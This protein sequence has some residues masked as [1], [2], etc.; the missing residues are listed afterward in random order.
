MILAKIRE[1]TIGFHDDFTS[2]ANNIFNGTITKDQYKFV[3]KTFYG[4]YYPLEQK[5]EA[6]EE[7][8]KI[9]FNIEGRRKALLAVKD[10]KVLGVSDQEINEIETCNDL[11]EVNNL[12]QALGCMYVLEGAT[13]GGQ[14]TANKL[15]EIFDFT[16]ENGASFFSSYGENVRPMWKSFGD[17]INRYSDENKIEDP[18]VNASHETYFK[19]NDWLSKLK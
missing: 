4:F 13:L 15:K 2:W 10:L 17:L 16:P 9:D 5:I 6:P 8:E 11:P 1:K 12:A 19:L 18:I 3:L 7:W 14:L